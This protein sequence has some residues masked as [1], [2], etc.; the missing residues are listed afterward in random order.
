[1][2]STRTN[3]GKK[4]IFWKIRWQIIIS[5]FI[6]EFFF[7]IMRWLII[8][9]LNAT[10]NNRWII[11]INQRHRIKIMSHLSNIDPCKAIHFVFWILR[12]SLD[13]GIWL[14]SDIFD[15]TF[16]ECSQLLYFNLINVFS[17]NRKYKPQVTFRRTST[18]PEDYNCKHHTRQTGT[19]FVVDTIIG[20]CQM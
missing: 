7:N 8:M 11:N 14:I 17:Q 20:R 18:A 3:N 19:F 12:L 5:N 10:L 2:Y 16:K 13:L 15:V 6:G 1:M 4:H 9:I